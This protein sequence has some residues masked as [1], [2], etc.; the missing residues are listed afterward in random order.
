MHTLRVPWARVWPP[1]SPA[2]VTMVGNDLDSDGITGE[3]DKSDDSTYHLQVQSWAGVLP[4]PCNRA[5]CCTL[6]PLA[7][8]LLTPAPDVFACRC[9]RATP[10]GRRS[11]TA[12]L[13]SRT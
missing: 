5:P 9:T 11:T 2:Q 7:P 6:L 10:E 1:C 13:R 12:S 4:A 3:D 8:D